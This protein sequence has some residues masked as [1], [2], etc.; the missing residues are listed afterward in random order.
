MIFGGSMFENDE[1]LDVNTVYSKVDG[2]E[3]YIDRASAALLG[4]IEIDK[5]NK[6]VKTYLHDKEGSIIG[7]DWETDY[8][9]TIQPH[10]CRVTYIDDGI[11][12]EELWGEWNTTQDRLMNSVGHNN[13]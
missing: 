13:D 7:K 5:G 4:V 2:C 3:V 10:R 1:I 11:K 9:I 12:S 6:L 8:I